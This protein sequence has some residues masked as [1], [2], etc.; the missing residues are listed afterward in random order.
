M[1]T[2][3]QGC[4]TLHPRQIQLWRNMPEGVGFKHGR[5]GPI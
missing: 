5:G 4:I 2:N 3:Q 1:R